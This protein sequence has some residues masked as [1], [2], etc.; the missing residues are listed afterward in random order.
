MIA[1]VLRHSKARALERREAPVAAF[2][3][4]SIFS[5]KFSDS[6]AVAEEEGYSTRCLAEADEGVVVGRTVPIFATILRSRWKMRRRER[7]EKYRFANTSLVSTATVLARSRDQS[8]LPVRLVAVRARF[9][10][11]V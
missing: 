5:A 7:S 10:G 1:T 4:L 3:I 8:A 9:G 2:T 6:K 11:L